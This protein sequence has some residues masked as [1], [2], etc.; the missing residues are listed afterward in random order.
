MVI[1]AVVAVASAGFALW[2]GQALA[3][4]WLDIRASGAT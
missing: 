3:E 4:R 2:V 1:I